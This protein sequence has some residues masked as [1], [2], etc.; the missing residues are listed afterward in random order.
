MRGNTLPLSYGPRPSSLCF[1]I[2][3]T[4]LGVFVMVAIVN[5]ILNN[6]YFNNLINCWGFICL[7]GWFLG[8]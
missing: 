2:H 7:F 3:F 8:F 4:G 5:I 6:I 1:K